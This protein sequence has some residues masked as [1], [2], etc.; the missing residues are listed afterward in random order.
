MSSTIFGRDAL[1][2][3][4]QQHQERI[5]HQRARH[6]EH[7]LL[8]AAHPPAQPVA[9]LAQVGKDAEQLLRR[10]GGAPLA[11]RLA[12]HFEILQH[13]ELAEDAPV[14]GHIAQPQPRDLERLQP[15]QRSARGTSLSPSMRSTSP[16]M[17]LNVVDL[18]GAVAAHQR[19][20]LAAPPRAHVEQDLRPPVP[21]AIT[22]QRAA[23]PGAFRPLTPQQRLAVMPRRASAAGWKLAPVPEVNRLHLRDRRAPVPVRPAR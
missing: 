16:M 6:G 11:R 18:P 3:L 5:A 9:H 8:A 22:V 21:Q 13:R 19:D 20:D 23:V 14:L 1:G 4:V 12:A 7:L 15:A 10:P 2:G 17:A